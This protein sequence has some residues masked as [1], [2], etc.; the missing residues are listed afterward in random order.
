MGKKGNLDILEES[1]SNLFKEG[2][3]SRYLVLRHFDRL[4]KYIFGGEAS[5]SVSSDGEID[6]TDRRDVICAG[7]DF[8]NSL[9]KPYY[10]TEMKSRYKIFIDGI[11]TIELKL[12]NFLLYSITRESAKQEY[13]S[14]SYNATKEKWIEIFNNH[15]KYFSTMLM[16]LDKKTGHYE[17]FMYDKLKIYME[18][19]TQIN[20]LLKRKT[21]MTSSEYGEE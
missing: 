13:V 10:D 8:L 14:L 21:W 2:S 5:P 7:I 12:Y 17:R 9:I 4:S 11:K 1:E 15:K 20:Y 6:T 19:F 3:E 16:P 18:L